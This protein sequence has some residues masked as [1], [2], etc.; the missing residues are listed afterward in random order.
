LY[1]ERDLPVTTDFRDVLGEL[2]AHHLGQQPDRVF[3]GH[4][5]G[6]TLGVLKV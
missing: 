1:E 2:V 5:A 6:A 3:P 4:K